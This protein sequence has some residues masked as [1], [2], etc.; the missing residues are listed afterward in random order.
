[1]GNVAEMG[2][3]MTYTA[4]LTSL[5]LHSAFLVSTPMASAAPSCGPTTRV[6]RCSV[7]HGKADDFLAITPAE[8]LAE[9]RW[10][11]VTSIP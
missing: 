1:M 9:G 3:M 4:M 11:N 2:R 7:R 5:H 8:R 6:Q 10:R